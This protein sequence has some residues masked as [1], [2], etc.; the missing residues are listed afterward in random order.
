MQATSG[1]LRQCGIKSNRP[2]RSR[3]MGQDVG[4]IT[5][6]ADTHIGVAWYRKSQWDRLRSLASD[7]DKLASTYDEWLATAEGKFRDMTSL[8]HRLCRIEVDVEMLWAWC[9]AN[10]RKLDGPAR[11][12]YVAGRTQQIAAGSADA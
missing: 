12:E 9:S 1:A 10:G 8:G 4:Q 11:A 5:M 7:G 2:R 3:L 6:V